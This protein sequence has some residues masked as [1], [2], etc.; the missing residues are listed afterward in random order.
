M[1]LVAKDGGAA[2][3]ED[4]DGRTGDE[5]RGEGVEEF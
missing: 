3:F 1:K 5:L 2:G 4:D